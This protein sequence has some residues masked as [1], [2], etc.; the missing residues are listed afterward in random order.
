MC[1]L[2]NWSPLFSPKKCLNLRAAWWMEESLLKPLCPVVIGALCCRHHELPNQHLSS[3]LPSPQSSVSCTTS[4]S[5]Q[6]STP[7]PPSAEERPGGDRLL[8]L[9]PEERRLPVDPVHR[10]R[11]HQPQ[12]PARTQR[13]LGQL[14]PEVSATAAEPHFF[15]FSF[16][17]GGLL[18]WAEFIYMRAPY[19][20]Q[21]S[22]EGIDDEMQR[23]YWTSFAPSDMWK[24][25]EGTLKKQWHQSRAHYQL[26]LTA[27]NLIATLGF[28]INIEDF[29]LKL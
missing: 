20:V 7:S 28:G 4:F 8:P 6:P 5:I 26:M 22:F 11:L 24:T 12:S 23:D 16:L 15:L 14:R 2:L 29:Y 17:T 19:C 27:K 25:D 18:I 21:R 3:S 13:H 10:H 1:N 9:A